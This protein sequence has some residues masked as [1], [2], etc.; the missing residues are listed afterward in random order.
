MVRRTSRRTSRR[1]IKRKTKR[2]IKF[3]P[4]TYKRSKF[5]TGDYLTRRKKRKHSGDSNRKLDS[6]KEAL[7]PGERLSKYGN[8][9]SE[10]RTNRSDLNRRKKE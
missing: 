1:K 3:V 5:Q 7:P 4:K 2:E 9:Y 10:Y 6:Q 8:T